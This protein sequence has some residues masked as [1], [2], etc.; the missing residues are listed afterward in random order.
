MP[1]PNPDRP[2]TPQNLKQLL[3]GRS[4]WF[5][6]QILSSIHRSKGLEADR[7]FVLKPDKMALTW[8]N[9]LAWQAEQEQN[10]RYVGLTRAKKALYFVEE[11]ASEASAKPEAQ[12]V[13]A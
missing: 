2:P 3:L 8:K 1:R 10:L 7:V 12:A 6:R 5:A 9:Q 11:N 4:D 13:P